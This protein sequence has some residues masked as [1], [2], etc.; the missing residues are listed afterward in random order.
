M[1]RIFFVNTCMR[2]YANTGVT[3][4]ELCRAL[5]KIMALASGISTGIRY[6][7]NARAALITRG[8]VEI[9]RLGKKVSCLEQTFSGLSGIGDLIVTATSLHS[10]HNRCGNFIGKV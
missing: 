8:V 5:K 1:P 9:T 6:E 3:G 7:D 4:V 2:V 10:R